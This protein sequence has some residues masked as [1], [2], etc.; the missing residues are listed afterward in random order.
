MIGHGA[1]GFSCTAA[2][3]AQTLRSKMAHKC[4]STTDGQSEVKMSAKL[5][6]TKKAKHCAKNCDEAKDANHS[7]ILRINNKGTSP[8]PAPEAVSAGVSM[9]P[10]E[11]AR[12]R[13]R[14][15]AAARPPSQS[16]VIG[17]IC[18]NEARTPAGSV[19]ALADPLQSH[20]KESPRHAT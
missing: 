18:A 2:L 15:P 1:N 19:T 8:Y 10:I 4:Q 5:P 11:P 3:G 20:A 14:R 9:T 16:L 17:R 7:Q 6:A 13:S 12:T